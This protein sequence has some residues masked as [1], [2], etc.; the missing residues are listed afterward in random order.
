MSEAVLDLSLQVVRTAR[1]LVAEA[2]AESATAPRTEPPPAARP[3]EEPQAADAPP[4]PPP[5]RRPGRAPTAAV[6]PEHVDEEAVLAA[7]FAEE[8][9]EGGAGPEIEVDEPWE[10]YSGMRA[11]DVVRALQDASTE[12]LAAVQLYERSGRGRRTVLD[13][14]ERLL[15]EGESA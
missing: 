2:E 8:G 13:A 1:E 7:E 3:E 6:E 14:A 5:R 12:T 10:G 11:P 4:A 9:A 15:S